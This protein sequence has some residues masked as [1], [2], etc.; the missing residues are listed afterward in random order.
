MGLFDNAGIFL[1][2]RR[3]MHRYQLPFWS[4]RRLI[5]KIVD[6]ACGYGE[7]PVSVVFFSL[8]VVCFFGILFFLFGIQAH[9]HTIRY[10]PGLPLSMMIYDIMDSLYF[11]VVTFT[12][13]GYGDIIPIGISRF[14]ATVEAFAGS[15]IL[16]LFVVVFVNKMT[17]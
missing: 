17:R 3:I 16:A 2:K 8:S 4:G 10:T 9:D 15:F 1:R 7:S 12:T 11:S 13:V 6:L 5:S 14:F